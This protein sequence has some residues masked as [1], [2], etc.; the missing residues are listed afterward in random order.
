MG[1]RLFK[2]G[3]IW[4]AWIPKP[5]GGV[6][7]KTTLCTDR[8]AALIVAA[9]LERAAVDP[10]YATKNEAETASLLTSYI[11]SRERLGRSEGT[12]NHV[13]TK[14]G[15][16][17]RLLPARAVEIT[18]GEV[19]TYIDKRLAE[20]ARR[21]TIKKEIRIL[22]ATLRLAAKKELFQADPNNIIPE[23]EDDYTP[24]TRFLLPMELVALVRELGEDER[25][26]MVAFIVAT[27][28]RWGEA[29]RAQRE[30]VTER[31]GV[32][33][34]KLRGTKTKKSAREVPILG[35]AQGLL[36]W[37]LERVGVQHTQGR[38]RADRQ[39]MFPNWN[40][41]RRDLVAACRRAGIQ[42][43]SPNDLRRTFATWMQQ[44]GAG[45]DLIAQA[46]G[47]TDSRMVE[48][49]YG[50][51]GSDD[52]ARLLAKRTEAPATVASD[53]FEAHILADATLPPE[54]RRTLLDLTR[55]AYR[56][57]VTGAPN[58]VL[59][60]RGNVT[61]RGQ[62]EAVEETGGCANQAETSAFVVPRDGIE[63]PTRGFSIRDAQ[64]SD[65]PCGIG[66]RDGFGTLQSGWCAAN[67]RHLASLGV[68]AVDASKLSRYAASEWVNVVGAS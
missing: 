2:R 57:L 55:E 6:E 49:V 8:K 45:N 38:A 53:S 32:V 41:V 20:G 47:H 64:I 3:L 61:D 40:S 39:G 28:A 46:M 37:A 48:R 27:S 60:M 44:A 68:S 23:L 54:A 43:V 9:K 30:D 33:F 59:L 4:H 56:R 1:D 16:L 15:H 52:L 35:A 67:A 19:E 66:D 17:F 5:G 65:L 21:T 29:Q 31:G 50:K 22:K 11:A 13:N 25:A 63:P 14:A 26:A 36:A 34:A 10:G 24:R 62:S 18:H 58:R 51:M 7:R 42:P 12:M